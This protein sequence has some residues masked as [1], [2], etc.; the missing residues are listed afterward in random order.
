MEGRIKQGFTE[1]AIWIDG[2]EHHRVVVTRG[3]VAALVYSIVYGAY[4]YFVVYRYGHWIAVLGEQVNWAIMYTGLLVTVALATVYKKRVHV[5]Q[6]IMGL[7]FMALLED[8]TYWACQWADTGI[9]PFPAPDWWDSWFATFRVLGHM[10]RALPFWPFV[11][12]Y[13]V[14][15]FAA[16]AIFYACSFKGPAPSRVAFL[17]IGPLFAAVLLGVLWNNDAY[18]IFMLVIL[19]VSFYCYELLLLSRAGWTFRVS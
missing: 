13:Y 18:A 14:P 10:G 1:R 12:V 9:Y 17:A 19:P 2:P 3:F 15:G 7:L 8:V 16:V 4:E 6:A 11:P 5:E